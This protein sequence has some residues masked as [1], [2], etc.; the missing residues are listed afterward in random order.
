MSLDP[1][2]Q[3]SESCAVQQYPSS[4][5]GDSTG[6]REVYS[7]LSDAEAIYGLV[8]VPERALA[9]QQLAA[10]FKIGASRPL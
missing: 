10:S 4:Y 1:I 2:L 9:I 5:N 3:L 6:H 8:V 7:Q